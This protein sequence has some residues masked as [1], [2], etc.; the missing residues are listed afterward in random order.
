[1]VSFQGEGGTDALS[2]WNLIVHPR[3]KQVGAQL[4]RYDH[5]IYQASPQ[6]APGGE[7]QPLTLTY[8]DGFLTV[9]LGETVLFDEVSIRAIP[10][11]HRIGVS[12]YGPK[13]G[14]AGFEL[15]VPAA[16]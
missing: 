2:G 3:R 7:I 13:L 5:V 12:T 1:M 10:G 6:D 4:E 14:F 16:R 11:K 9:T 8:Y 15:E